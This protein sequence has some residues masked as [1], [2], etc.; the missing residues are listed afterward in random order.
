MKVGILGSG[1]VGRT[2]SDGFLG[3]AHQVLVGT[4]DPKA[5][6]VI[7]WAKN[8]ARR[9]VANYFEDSEFGE[10]LVLSLLARVVEDVIRAPGLDN[11]RGK[12]LIDC[13]TS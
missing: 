11:F 5:T 6:D 1:I 8:T 4:C 7:A 3:Q 12:T 10:L 9:K 13:R 2:L